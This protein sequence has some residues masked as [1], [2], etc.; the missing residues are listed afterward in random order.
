MDLR[1]QIAILRAWLPL[2]VVSVLLAAG[3]AF[4]I[5]SQLPKVYEAKATLNVGQSL[6]AVN[7]DYTQVLVSQNLSAT[8]ATVAT[9]RP[10][11]DAAIAQLGLGVTPDDLL[12]HVRADA[13]AS[14]GAPRSGSDVQ[15]T[16]AHRRVH[17][18]SSMIAMATH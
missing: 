8:Y 3:A 13:S 11:L 18:S 4:A 12:S 9:T 7:P 6:S 5:S 2:L 14:D 10:I 15:P 17:A 16:A 1:R